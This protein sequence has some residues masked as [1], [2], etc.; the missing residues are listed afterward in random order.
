MSFI[1]LNGASHASSIIHTMGVSLLAPTSS[2]YYCSTVQLPLARRHTDLLLLLN[3][4]YV[5]PDD[6]TAIVLDATHQNASL[7]PLHL[8]RAKVQEQEERAYTY[9]DQIDDAYCR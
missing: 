9:H 1:H 7:R 5:H 8:K 3:L 6:P 4:L 2:D